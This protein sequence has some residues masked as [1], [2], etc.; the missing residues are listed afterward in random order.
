VCRD[1]RSLGTTA[2]RESSL[3]AQ[4]H[5]THLALSYYRGPLLDGETEAAWVNRPRA[6]HRDALVRLLTAAAQAAERAGQVEEVIELYR[7]GCEVEPAFEPLC[8]RLMLVL[9]RADRI[10]EAVEAYQRHRVA[11]GGEAGSAASSQILDLYRML[12]AKL[13]R[14]N[15]RGAG[16]GSS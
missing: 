14:D 9:N 10:A 11:C 12:L 5:L 6:E 15:S 13:N 3:E 4:L 7:R 1:L 8:Y 16:G 2:G